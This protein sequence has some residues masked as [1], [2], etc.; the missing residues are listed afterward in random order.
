MNSRFLKWEN[1]HLNNDSPSKRDIAILP[2]LSRSGLQ[3]E[4]KSMQKK[5]S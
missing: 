1:L 3:Y 4:L 5:N 2:V